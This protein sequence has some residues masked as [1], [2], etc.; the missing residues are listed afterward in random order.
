[1]A[2]AAVLLLVSTSIADARSRGS[3]G[4]RGSRTNEAP[5]ATQTAPSTAQPMQRTQ[6][7]PGQTQA[8]PAASAAQAAQPARGRFG[9]G[10]MAGLLGAGLLGAL[11]GAGL[12]GGLGSLASILGFLLQIM[13]IGGLIFL[14]V[15]FFRARRQSSLAG[16]GAGAGG[17]MQ[18]STLGSMMPPAAGTAPAGMGTGVASGLGT[19]AGMGAAA[20]A[21]PTLEEIT[22]TDEDFTSFEHM[23][24]TV[25][26]AYGREDV[27]ALWELTTPEMAGYYQEELNENAR[28][29]VRGTI[30]DVKL[31]Q[32]DLSEAWREG[33]TEYATVAMRYSI[34]EEVVERGSGKTISGGTEEATEVWTFRRDQGAAWKLSAVQQTA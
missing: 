32:G 13:L 3:M 5:A 27:A 31:L 18:R 7:T 10:F 9:G 23:L 15:R 21:R 2:L 24:E 8:G 4:S 16:A 25:Q 26:M 12:F 6:T 11:F 30:S 19:A 29:G 33:A 14:A 20:A 17:P 1:M 22:L 28:K 34:T